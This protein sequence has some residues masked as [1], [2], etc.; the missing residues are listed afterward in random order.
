MK[1]SKI[2]RGLDSS[3]FHLFSLDGTHIL[4][5][6]RGGLYQLDDEIYAFLAESRA[7]D[8]SLP[9]GGRYEQIRRE[10][11]H[12]R[13]LEGC[14]GASTPS[15]E[16]ALRALCLNVTFGCTM[17]C[18]YCFARGNGSSAAGLSMD[19]R[20]AFS[21]VDFLFAHSSPSAELQIDFFG[22][23]PLLCLDV[24]RE[25]V[26]YARKKALRSDRRVRFTL[27]TNGSLLDDE[28]AL[29]LDRED[30]SVILSLDGSP[31]IHN[32]QRPFSG[33]GPSW[34]KVFPRMARFLERRQYQNY[35]IRG[36][37]TPSSLGLSSTAEFLLSQAL[38]NFSL[39]PARGKS[40]EPWS[41]KE[42]NL[43]A[44]CHEYECLA[45]LALSRHKEKKA[46]NF[47]HFNVFLDSPIC[48]TRRLTGCGAGV[49]YLSIGP[50]GEI[51]PCHQL[52][53]EKSFLMGSVGEGDLRGEFLD[54]RAHF[55]E[56]HVANKETCSAC[57]AR[58]YCSGGCHANG[59]IHKGSIMNP[60]EVGCILQR[61]RLECALWVAALK[62]SSELI[63]TGQE[64]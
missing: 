42:E 34:E 48:V 46:F 25:T 19:S 13:G 44:L 32:K 8:A 53:G 51:Y 30:F 37:F 49:E 33:A 12:V 62:K 5:S 2:I 47:F 14:A 38:Y 39:E 28:A 35:Y 55:L 50:G 18:I 3:Q 29:F 21:A 59:Y 24:V 26:S 61:K 40:H 45:R 22:G 17:E 54:V 56:A 11:D 10:L 4:I 1:T 52:H 7:E 58:Y 57:W 36:T 16:R 27:T 23:E 20:T 43:P 6:A 9:S 63:E 60:D 41:I 31:E 64:L 15:S